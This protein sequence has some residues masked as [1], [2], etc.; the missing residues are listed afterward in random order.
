MVILNHIIDNEESYSH[1][2]VQTGRMQASDVNFE[3]DASI[4]MILS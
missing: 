4:V 3:D 2:S 1:S